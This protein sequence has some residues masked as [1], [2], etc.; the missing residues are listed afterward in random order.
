MGKFINLLLVERA[1]GTP[2][3]V[4]APYG[5]GSEGDLVIFGDP[6]HDIGMV[7]LRAGDREDSPMAQF[8]NAITTVYSA[9]QIFHPGYSK[10][11]NDGE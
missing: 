6:S 10:E 8:L 1:D 11:D 7:V 9:Q 2:A 4:S 5:T 3:V